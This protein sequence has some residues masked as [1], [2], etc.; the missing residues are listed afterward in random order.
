MAEHVERDFARALG[1][2]LARFLREKGIR[3]SEASRRLGLGKARINTYCHDSPKGKRPKP[4]AEV[5]YRICAEFGFEF[6]YAGYRISATTLKGSRLKSA[7]R[8]PEQLLLGFDR[9][10]DLTNEQGTVSISVR[11]PAG[12]VEVSVT[13]S[14]VS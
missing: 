11:R 10:F 8:R 2:A 14:A 6:E 9:Q 4:D 7:E 5:L 3:Q 1:D 12:R 13:L